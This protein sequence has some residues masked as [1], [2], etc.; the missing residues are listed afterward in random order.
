MIESRVGRIT[1]LV[2]FYLDKVA[3]TGSSP[4]ATTWFEVLGVCLIKEG[5]S[6][7]YG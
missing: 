3:V 2:E 1:Q 4:V 7:Q 5:I 6:Y